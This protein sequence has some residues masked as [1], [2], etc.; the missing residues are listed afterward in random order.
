M[1]I[2]EIISRPVGCGGNTPLKRK[3]RGN[4]H[5]P[6]PSASPPWLKVLL[7]LQVAP[8]HRNPNHAWELIQF[9][10]RLRQAPSAFP[11]HAGD[12]LLTAPSGSGG[13]PAFPVAHGVRFCFSPD[14]DAQADPADLLGGSPGEASG[15]PGCQ[16]GFLHG[17]PLPL[18]LPIVRAEPLAWCPSGAGGQPVGGRRLELA[19]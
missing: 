19:V 8:R 10:K 11:Q 5:S 17:V 6:Q 4:A 13:D 9:S 12:A 18:Q 16:P 15:C 7:H 1:V 14:V 3:Q 2:I